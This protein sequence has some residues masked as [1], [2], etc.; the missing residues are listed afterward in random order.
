M[1]TVR[2]GNHAKV[3]TLQGFANRWG[4]LTQGG[5]AL[6]PGL[7]PQA[8]LGQMPIGTTNSIGPRYHPIALIRIREHHISKFYG[9]D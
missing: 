7:S 5:A 9:T 3:S 1:Q 4:V 8:P 6:Y 2:A